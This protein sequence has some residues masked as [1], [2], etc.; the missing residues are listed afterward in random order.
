[1]VPSGMLGNVSYASIDIAVAAVKLWPADMEKLY[2]QLRCVLFAVLRPCG[3]S[4]GGTDSIRGVLWEHGVAWDIPGTF[5]LQCQ[6]AHICIF[7][8]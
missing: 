1:M 8:V 5:T 7:P 2:R 6:A 3:V 4:H